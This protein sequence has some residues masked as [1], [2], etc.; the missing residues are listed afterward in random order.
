MNLLLAPLRQNIF[1]STLANIAAGGFFLVVLTTDNTTGAAV[2]T[3]A[4]VPTTP[5]QLAASL[6]S[7]VFGSGGFGSN[8]G[9]IALMS[10]TA[11]IQLQSPL[12]VLSQA[13]L[14]F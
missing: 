8:G 3:T 10:T 4:L 6:P 5:K 11:L 2:L 12:Q 1:F 9:K 14:T 13:L 7:T